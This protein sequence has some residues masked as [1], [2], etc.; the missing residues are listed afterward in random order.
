MF[1]FG[2]CCFVVDCFVFGV[3]TCCLCF[4]LFIV[5]GLLYVVCGPCFVIVCCFMLAVGW[6][7]FI[8]SVVGVRCL[9]RVA[10]CLLRARRCCLLFV[11]VRCVLCFG[12]AGCLLLLDVIVCCLLMV[13]VWR[14]RLFVA[15]LLL[16]VCLEVCWFFVVCCVLLFVVCCVC[17]DRCLVSVA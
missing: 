10:C 4:V 6:L 17:V 1:V 13:V 5:C 9:L 7:L 8:V 15:F 3:V 11:V 12:I 14:C 2:V 16:S